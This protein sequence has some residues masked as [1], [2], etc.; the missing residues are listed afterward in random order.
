MNL[1][2]VSLEKRRDWARQIENAVKT[3][4]RHGVVWGDV[5][6]DNVLIH[7]VDETP[8]LIDFGGSYTNGWIEPRLWETIEGDMQGLQKIV[9][10]LETGTS[11]LMEPSSS[12]ENLA[13]AD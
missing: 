9:E 3:L 1:T 8:W 13:I 4:H 5:K 6:A 11:E 12:D 7:C 2:T 10:F